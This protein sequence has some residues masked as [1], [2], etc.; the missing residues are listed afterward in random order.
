MAPKLR[1]LRAE[2]VSGEEL[3][4][5]QPAVPSC[6]A[7]LCGSRMAEPKFELPPLRLPQL[8][9]LEE[10]AP[11]EEGGDEAAAEEKPPA[12]SRDVTLLVEIWDKDPNEDGAAALFPGQV[13]IAPVLGEE[14]PAEVVL[15]GKDDVENTLGFKYEL[16]QPAPEPDEEEEAPPA[17][18]EEAQIG[19]S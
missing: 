15:K 11:A 9:A 3:P 2:A 13:E 8:E 6:R 12:G 19:A 10:A 1:G 14:T 16:E 17:E 5:P 18:E 4:P 7:V